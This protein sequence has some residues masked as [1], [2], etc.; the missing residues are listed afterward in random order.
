MTSLSDFEITEFC[1]ADGNS[2]F[3]EMSTTFQKDVY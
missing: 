1:M 2:E 3:L